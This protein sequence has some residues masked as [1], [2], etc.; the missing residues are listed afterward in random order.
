MATSK[1]QWSKSVKDIL[2]INVS[3]HDKPGVTSA[4]TAVLSRFAVTV[5]DIG[6]AVI[7]DQLNLGILAAVPQSSETAEM[8]SQVQSELLALGMHTRFQPIS[9]ADYQ[10]WVEQ[11]GKSRYIVT[12]LA[13]K[14]DA[15]HLA[16]VTKVTSDHGLNIDKIVRLSG[17]VRLDETHQLGR[18]CVEFSV[19]GEP[20]D[21]VQ[22]KSELLELSSRYEI[23]IAYQ[24]DTIFRRNRRLVVFDMDS[25]LID[26][27]VIDELAYEAGVGEQVAAITEAAMQ[28]ELDFKQSFT[29]RVGLLKGLSADVLQSVAERLVLNEGAEHLISTL[30]KLGYKTAIVSGG[31]TFFGQH[32]QKRL[33]V[34]YV[35]A[36]QL[37]IENG[38]VTGRVTG[39]II[40]GQRKAELLRQIAAQEGLRLEQVIAVGDGANDLPMLSIAGLGIAFRAK[41]LVKAS[42]KQSISNLGLDGILYLLGYSDKDTRLLD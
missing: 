17:R 5:L 3:G 7:H 24:E 14:I 20:T 27:E 36:N 39:D 4:V 42:A 41:P 15:D 30:R 16:A 32:L 37:D 18:A 34:D 10:H 28:G 31:F 38:Y 2:L 1:R 23:D 13:R 35:Y 9:E 26:A 22:F 19:R 25:T 8:T 12:L 29:Q 6:Q 21:A 40:D 33:G 11:Q